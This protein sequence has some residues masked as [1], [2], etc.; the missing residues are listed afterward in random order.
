MRPT[1]TIALTLGIAAS[2][3]LAH[4]GVKD[5]QVLAR[6]D[7]MKAMAG[8]LKTLGQMAKG[9]VTYDA[10]T[11]TAAL[12]SLKT[13]TNRIPALFS[14]QA[15]DPKSEAIPAIWTDSDGFA[16]RAAQM[17]TALDTTDVSSPEAIGA[18]L[19]AIGSAY[20]EGYRV[21]E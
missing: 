19:R 12:A 7:G 18:S 8:D 3:A 21:K 5:P 10:E 15:Q 14:P 6:M 4:T 13:Q 1:L 11:A 20:H 9:V 2:A 17:A 16:A